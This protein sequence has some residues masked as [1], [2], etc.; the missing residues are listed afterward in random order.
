[1]E[2][3]YRTG[4]LS[5]QREK[6]MVNVGIDLHKSQFTVCVNRGG[7]E[8]FTKYPATEDGYEAFLKRAAAWQKAGIGVVVI[9]T[10]KFKVVNESG[11]KSPG[12]RGGEKRSEKNWRCQ[13]KKKK[14]RLTACSGVDFL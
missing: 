10:L 13:Q 11:M 6:T 5:A 4:P 1:M 14:S 8:Q 9:N 3:I 2:H 12:Q 7:R